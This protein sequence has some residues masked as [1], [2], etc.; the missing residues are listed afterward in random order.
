M[1]TCPSESELRRHLESGAGGD[2]RD[3]TMAAA[4]G[5]A[6]AEH[7]ASCAACRGRLD[8]LCRE[9]LRE[10][11]GWLGH[12]PARGMDR[13]SGG[14]GFTPPT[15]PATGD[16]ART[17]DLGDPA[18]IRP[19]SDVS[20][21]LGAAGYEILR[22]LGRGG[23]GVVYK[24]R[25]FGLDRLVALKMIRG[26]A[27]AR[28]E[29]FARFRIEALAVARLRHPNIV[30]IF[31]IGEA[32]GLPFVAL[33][34]LDG[35]SL[36]SRLARSP[37]PGRP[38]AELLA[39]LAR[40]VRAAHTAGIVHRDLKPSN[41][42][43]GADGVPRI[44][45]FGLAKRLES[46]SHQTETGQ[47]MGSP[48][49][50][51]P[52]QARGHSRDVGPP[53]DIYA[54]GAILYEMLTGRPPFKGATPME[55][56]RQVVDD[57]PVPPS[58]L[59]P[60]VARDLETICLKCLN[61]EPSRRYDSALALAEDLERYLAG[62]PIKARRTPPW[63]RGAKW[64]R[65][66]PVTATLLAGLLVAIPVA[67]VRLGLNEHARRVRAEQWISWVRGQH[68]VGDRLIRHVEEARGADELRQAIGRLHEF[69]GRSADVR[70]L[71]ELL[72]R[73]GGCLGRES[74]RLGDLEARADRQARALVDRQRFGGFL[75][76]WG[77]A[78]LHAAGFELGVADRLTK[79]RDSAKAALAIYA[80]DPERR[81]EEWTLSA[82]LPEALSAT[83]RARII[84]GCYDLLLLLSQ[85]VEPAPGR[86]ILDRAA[87]LRPGPT[88]AY[89]LRRADALARSGDAG[90]RKR[91]EGLARQRPPATAL[92]NFLIGREHLL[93]GQLPEATVALETAT[94]LDP[95]QSAAHLLLAVASLNSEPKRLNEA[96]VSL[97]ACIRL[98]PGL[99]GLYL[100][101]AR[102]HGEEGNRARP[103]IDPRRPGER[104][105]L[106]RQADDAFRAA[107]ADYRTALGLH[108][109]DDYRYVIQVN[110]G[111]MRLQAD[112]LDESRADL[113]EAIRFRPTAPEAYMTLAQWH[114]RQGRL[115]EASEAFARAIER[116]ADPETRVRLHRGRAVLHVGR[117]EATPAQRAAA[118]R[119][120]DEA[121][122]LEPTDRGPRADDH[123][124]RARLLFSGDRFEDAL[125]ACGDAL[126]LVPD[127][128]EAHR[129][130]I[131]TLMA[132]KRY[133]EV[134]GSCDA[135]LAKSPP[136]V[137]VLEIR[138]LARV[139]RRDYPEAVAD[140][141]R[142][143]DLRTDLESS[144][145][146]RL[147][148]S[149]GWA[150]HFADA[151]RL[152]LS[153]FEA[154]LRLVPEQGDALAG[155]G[156]ARIRLGDWRPALADADAAVR[157]AATS[158]TGEAGPDARRR[159][160]LNAARIYALAVEYAAG[161]VTRQGDRAVAHY[162]QLRA[163]GLALLQEA[164]RLVPEEQRPVFWH[165]V[166]LPDPF[167]APL[168]IGPGPV[169]PARDRAAAQ[170][171]V[172]HRPF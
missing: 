124:Q 167:L 118:L 1:T 130:R 51:A 170:P 158:P 148:N 49:Y 29:H 25:Q 42:L 82:T 31:D 99:V 84:D 48:S 151:P 69:R 68:A 146:A 17:A 86:K 122:R 119:D 12:L 147:L 92:D 103:G 139:E 157:L 128:P 114:Q 98:H 155:R 162:R 143:I 28:P 19:E 54:L 160:N 62:E 77:Q 13:V 109:S 52:E 15:N 165:E 71:R 153:D 87:A 144:A 91:E 66:R 95:D 21:E 96:R 18:E 112:R 88:A 5:D 40:A 106:R 93:A 26:G 72:E 171:V 166:I 111:G 149:R 107:E 36:D 108:P 4:G 85:A 168:R 169:P 159:I 57:D 63:E 58:R 14:D 9:A 11:G 115:D 22:V 24:A 97:D 80:R 142:A 53:A 32:G 30:Q 27:Q 102:V 43:F 8:A 79:V 76:L 154:S 16:P 67:G 61:K 37:Q 47:V 133:G 156:L 135:Y 136:T 150:Y 41:V 33:E 44:T 45:D 3:S 100:L 127:H 10:A 56:M 134:L 117:R 6:L 163:R 39:T 23:M 120:L 46:D 75:D 116:A 101:R 172:P 131:S 123:V 34:L 64:A 129:L 35:G 78:H 137:E 164:L 55:T 141:T 94:R 83:E 145:K 90:G 152:A 65:R 7:V 121:I 81:V 59:V 89:H 70:D 50:M 161:E 2:S 140:F 126:R 132:L 110:R 104:A 105:L 74:R 60:R 20:A 138:G 125:A 73:V 113:E 38:A